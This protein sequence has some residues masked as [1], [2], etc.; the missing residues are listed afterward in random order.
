[1]GWR[2]RNNGLTMT[3]FHSRQ[4]NRVRHTHKQ[5]NASTLNFTSQIPPSIC[6]TLNT[7]RVK[8]DAT[9][10]KS[11]CSRTV[12]GYR[13]DRVQ[14]LPLVWTRFLRL[15]KSSTMM[16]RSPTRRSRDVRETSGKKSGEISRVVSAQCPGNG[17]TVA[18]AMPPGGRRDDSQDNLPCA[19][20][21]RAMAAP[22][23]CETTRN[24]VARQPCHSQGNVLQDDPLKSQP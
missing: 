19:R 16:Q 21:G 1:M 18:T 10:F 4:P 14:A 20:V 24:T 11:R 23:T 22:E 17:R 12:V 9:I 13:L 6:T 5:A 8:T 2:Q 7:R 3:T 15:A